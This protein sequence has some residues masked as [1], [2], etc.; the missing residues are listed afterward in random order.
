MLID[1][2]KEL[3][4]YDRLL[5]WIREREDIRLKRLHGEDKPWTN[6]EILQSFRFCNV[7]RMDDAV[8]QWLL[9]WYMPYVDH[10]NMILACCLG[11]FFN[12]P[13]TLKEIGFPLK[14]NN[15]VM[16]DV[17]HKLH[18]LKDDG[19]RIFN[20]AYIVST[21]GLTMDKI[22]C[23]LQNVIHVVHGER[24]KLDTDSMEY[25]VKAME[26][27]WG[28]STFMAGQV[29][30][31]YRWVSQG[32]WLDKDTWAAVGPGSARGMNRLLERPVG[33][34]VTQKR[35]NKE[36]P[37][38]IKELKQDL[39]QS[40]TCRLEAI[41]YQNCLCEYDKMCRVLFGEGKPKRRY[42]GKS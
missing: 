27:Y 10:P 2:V 11:R 35:F 12:N 3:S 39:P 37:A 28:F 1:K 21:N 30:A 25:S 29:I 31:D 13:D 26:R 24:P 33:M 16:E 15:K 36:L 14:W 41:D 4:P 22:D 19:K 38:L 40:I 8:S 42:N 6:D 17:R 34:K 9:D 7:R 32:N 18:M 5:Y 23:V 20:P